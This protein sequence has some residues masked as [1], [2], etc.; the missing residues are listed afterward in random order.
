MKL[1]PHIFR[2][3]VLVEGFYEIPVN[4]QTVLAYFATMMKKL[5]VTA[6]GPPF[7]NDSH[8]KGTPINEGWEAFQPL[9]ESGIAVYLWAPDKFFSIIIYT[10]KEFDPEAAVRETCA[11]FEAD[12]Y[13]HKVF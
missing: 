1:A 8:G 6:G 11:F 9:I 3:R 13:E 7:V 2:Q 4:E 5:G 12:T 10:C